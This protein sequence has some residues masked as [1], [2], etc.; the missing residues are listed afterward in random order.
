MSESGL[1]FIIIII[2]LGIVPFVIFLNRWSENKRQKSL[3]KHKA[4]S[5]TRSTNATSSKKSKP[6]L[7]K[8]VKNDGDIT[9][10]QVKL[11]TDHISARDE[12]VGVVEVLDGH[13]NTED[14]IKVYKDEGELLKSWQFL[15]FGDRYDANQRG[16]DFSHLAQQF[17]VE[18]QHIISEFREQGWTIEQ[19]LTS[20]KEDVYHLSR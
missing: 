6:K 15:G 2:I 7:I 11:L 13:Y 19:S 12:F 18:V 17:K 9:S 8:K 5:R 1:L 3:S 4:S 16:S 10:D 20:S 14:D